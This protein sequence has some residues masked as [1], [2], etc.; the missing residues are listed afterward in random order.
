[1]TSLKVPVSSTD[2]IQGDKHASVTL[3]E[4][5]DYQ[6]PYCGMAYSILKK[7]QKH[8]ASDLR[9]VFRNFPLTEIHPFA[10][11]AAELAEFAA[12]Y[13][14]FWEMHDLLYEH[15]Q[16]LSLDLF[17]ELGRVLDL[18]KADLTEAI[19]KRFFREKV[20]KDFIGG[21]RSGVNGTPTFFIN[22]YRYNGSYELPVL[23]ATIDDI[24]KSNKRK[25]A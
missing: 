10:E 12:S 14:K 7:L 15:Q 4:Y 23:I 21:I 20:Q 2:H 11:P 17:V 22:G 16:D 5:G 3:V 1:M 24:L 8:F 9:F 6:C 13:G 19:E 25:V 18:P